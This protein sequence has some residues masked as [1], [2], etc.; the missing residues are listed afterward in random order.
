MASSTLADRLASIEL[1]FEDDGTLLSD[2]LLEVA[3]EVF[4]RTDDEPLKELIDEM[5]EIYQT[6]CHSAVFCAIMKRCE[7]LIEVCALS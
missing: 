1:E 3:S 6:D 4:A 5:R 2:E 7:K